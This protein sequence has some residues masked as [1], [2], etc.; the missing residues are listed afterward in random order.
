MRSVRP[1][2]VSTTFLFLILS[3]HP[4]SSL[5]QTQTAI[6]PLGK[7]WKI[8]EGS[9]TRATPEHFAPNLG[10]NYNLV[11]KDSTTGAYVI[12]TPRSGTP[13]ATIG[14][15]AGDIIVALDNLPFQRPEDLREHVDRTTI[16][17]I[18][19]RDGETRELVAH[20]PAGE[21]STPLP[22]GLQLGLTART[23]I[24]YPPPNATQLQSSANAGQRAEPPL[25][26]LEITALDPGSPAARSGLQIGDVITY[27]RASTGA[28]VPTSKPSIL[29]RA[30][31]DSGP[32][33]RL[34]ICRNYTYR[35]FLEVPV[36]LY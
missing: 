11:K 26:G 4:A 12:A 18:D 33:M 20:L 36:R 6:P 3:S 5:S 35:N 23:R 13:A 8:L 7:G 17:L 30:M 19:V 25:Y 16:T 15:E 10:I 2:L 9:L 32:T 31:S 1:F 14:I 22:G 27:F 28:W 24:V 29:R 34:I 21:R